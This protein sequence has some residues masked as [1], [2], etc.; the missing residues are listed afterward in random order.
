MTA[1]SAAYSKRVAY[2]A[3]CIAA[4]I[5]KDIELADF[6]SFT[7]EQRAAFR[8]GYYDTKL[9]ASK[10]QIKAMVAETMGWGEDPHASAERGADSAARGEAWGDVA[11]AEAGAEGDD[12]KELRG[13]NEAVKAEPGWWSGGVTCQLCGHEWVGV[14]PDDAEKAALECPACHAMAGMPEPPLTKG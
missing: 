14:W 4:H 13:V 2:A 10:A 8:D 1:P 12:G 3:G 9:V 5:G 6:S 7:T 11:A